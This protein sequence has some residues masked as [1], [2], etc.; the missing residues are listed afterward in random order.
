MTTTR[1]IA[2][3]AEENLKARLAESRSRTD[4][5]FDIIRPDA[6]YD[7][8]I[9]ERHRIVFYVGHLVAVEHRLMHAETLAYIFHHLPHD[10]KIPQH[11]PP[12]P[13][14]N[15]ARHDLI[16]IPLGVATLGLPRNGGR[17]GWDNEFEQHRLFVPGFSIQ[18]C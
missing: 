2:P 15:R 1:A 18:R 10:R 11:E 16:E 3:W 13:Y 5:L 17:F 8:T 6:L 4:S 14:R 12:A 9:P 7:R